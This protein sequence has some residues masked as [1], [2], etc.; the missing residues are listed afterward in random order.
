MYMKE[1]LLLRDSHP[2]TVERR[3]F[4]EEKALPGSPYPLT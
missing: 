2:L 4:E 1:R 3:D